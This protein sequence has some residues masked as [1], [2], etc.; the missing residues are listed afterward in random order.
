MIKV[1]NRGVPVHPPTAEFERAPPRETMQFLHPTNRKL[2]GGNTTTISKSKDPGNENRLQIGL[3]QGDS[4]LYYSA[5]DCNTT[6]RQRGSN[7]HSSFNFWR[8]SLSYRMMGHIFRNNL[9]LSKQGIK[10][11]RLGISRFTC[12]SP[13]G[14]S[15]STIFQRQHS[16]RGRKRAYR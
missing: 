9:Q 4:P 2:D 15:P 13:R 10:M 7:N 8:R 14:H 6:P 11:R 1:G 3:P 12:F 16:F 5:E